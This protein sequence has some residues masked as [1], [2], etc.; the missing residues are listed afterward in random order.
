MNAREKASGAPAP[1]DAGRKVVVRT[2]NA[3]MSLKEDQN[4]DARP[5]RPAIAKSTGN[6]LCKTPRRNGEKCR[7]Y[8]VHGAEVCIKHGGNLPNVK[9]KARRVL[10]EASRSAAEQMVKFIKDKDAPYAVRLKAAQEVLDRS[11]VSAKQEVDINITT[12]EKIV[13][14]GS[15]LVDLDGEDDEEEDEE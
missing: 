10:A 15:V 1:R 6:I 14:K 8:A 3:S 12:F 5:D 7:N 2:S 11:G 13:Q 9:A 4:P